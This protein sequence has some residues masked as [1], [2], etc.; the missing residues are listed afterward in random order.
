M[1]NIIEE[2]EKITVNTKEIEILKKHFPNCFNK[3][4]E[5]QMDK[6]EKRISQEVD[7]TKEGYEL[8]WLGK[9]YARLLANIETD[10]M[11]VDDKEHNDKVENKNS[12]NI[13]IEGDN[14][15]VL[16]HLKNAYSEKIKMIYIDPPYNTGSDGFVYKDDRKYTKEDLAELT[17][18]TEEEAQ[19]ILSFNTKGSNS[20]SAWLT[21][22]YPRL[23]TARELLS[24]DGVIFISIDDNEVSQLKLLCD[25]V[26]GEENFVTSFIWK[27]GKEGGNDSK[28]MRSHYDYILTYAKNSY[29]KDIINLDKKPFLHI[30]EE[31]YTRAKKYSSTEEITLKQ[32][33]A[34]K[35]KDMNRNQFHE[36]ILNLN[37]NNILT[38]NYDYNFTPY[39]TGIK[40]KETK[41]SLYRYQMY[42][43][44]KIW[45]IHG[46]INAP[47]SIMIGY[48]H[49]MSSIHNIQINQKENQKE[50]KKISWIDIF[51]NDN[52]YILGLGLDFGEIDL[53]W[54][55]SYR[56]RL[57]LDNK[58]QKNKV[59]YIKNKK[60]ISSSI[61]L[62]EEEKINN[63]LK[64]KEEK[65]KIEML[66]VF[67]VEI[68]EII[69][70]NN[71]IDYY[72]QVIQFL[73]T[74]SIN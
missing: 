29:C 22:M 34:R 15:D 71:Y 43:N 1:K 42:N 35:L 17:N 48:E 59:I 6:F 28:I 36:K 25:E 27:K 12:E 24:D 11:I 23:L 56:N 30:Y 61:N 64:N 63:I 39:A 57:I 69:F 58:I 5:F 2:N 62:S 10:T 8:R 38:T 14:I 70:E 74:D 40:T 51:L 49:Y 53:W 54:L 20:H 66:K 50:N 9:N 31:I 67:G 7:V 55:L 47:E 3:D 4:G 13:Y 26:F 19:R 52:I 73:K 32:Q 41:Y 65:A 21:F 44:T 68:K 37:F 45:H 18:I 46:E 33:I 60:L 72:N 16:K